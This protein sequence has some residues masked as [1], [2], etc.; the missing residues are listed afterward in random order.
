MIQRQA[1]ISSLT[2][3]PS[4]RK[5]LHA[6]EVHRLLVTFHRNSPR[7]AAS[8][9]IYPANEILRLPGSER[10]C[11]PQIISFTCLDG[12]TSEA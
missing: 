10:G 4:L 6:H 7:N 11:W 2:S 12:S 9:V 3:A 1:D 5:A 8:L